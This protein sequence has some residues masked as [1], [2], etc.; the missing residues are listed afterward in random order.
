MNDP[1]QQVKAPAIALLVSAILNGAAALLALLGGVFRLVAGNESLPTSENE[2]L[3]F[4]GGTILVYGI[5]AITLVCT[6]IIGF[7]AYKMMSGKSLGLSRTAAYLSVIPV[8]TCCIF[9]SVP[10]GI[11]A[12]VVLS[13]AEVKAMFNGEDLNYRIP[14]VPPSF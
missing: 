5:C 2:R 7:G 12:I 8:S 3:G 11:W 10:I 14:P 1:L 13:R 9:L 4:I 6:P